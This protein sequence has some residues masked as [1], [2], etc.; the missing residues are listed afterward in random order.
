[1]MSVLKTVEAIGRS[2]KSWNDAVEEVLRRAYKTIIGIREVELIGR[3]AE[4]SSEGKVEYEAR[5]LVS[6][7]LVDELEPHA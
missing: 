5:V 4:V 1:M 7:E 6:F 2:P 3:S